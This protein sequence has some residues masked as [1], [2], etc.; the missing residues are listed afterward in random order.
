MPARFCA[1]VR[2]DEPT[3]GLVSGVELE[4]ARLDFGAGSD[5][6]RGPLGASIGGRGSEPAAAIASVGLSCGRAAVDG[7]DDVST[8][9]PPVLASSKVWL[10]GSRGLRGMATITAC[11][12]SDASAASI[13]TRNPSGLMT[14]QKRS[15]AVSAV[16]SLERA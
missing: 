13:H 11:S 15:C 7:I 4:A 3:T 2:A 16:E 14:K 6:A 9:L 1:R 12:A 10:G 8:P 5:F